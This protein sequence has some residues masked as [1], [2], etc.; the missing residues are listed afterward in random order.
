MR[1]FLLSALKR[2]SRMNAEQLRTLLTSFEEEY[3]LF[4]ATMD[5]IYDGLILLDKANI[6]VKVNRAASRILNIHR[7]ELQDKLFWECINCD[8]IALFVK[9]VII[10]EEVKKTETFILN[11]NTSSTPVYIEVSIFP[12]VLEKKVIG[13]IIVLKD[14]TKEKQDEIRQHRLESLASLSNAAAGVAHEINNPIGAMSIHAQ[15]LEKKINTLAIDNDDK[16]KILKHIHV[17][18]EEIES[19]NKTVVNFLFAVRPI[20]FEFTNIHINSL[21]NS[22]VELYDEEFKEA[23]IKIVLDL[24]PTIHTILGDERFIRQAFVNIFTNAKA[25]M[26]EGGNFFISTYEKDNLVYISFEDTGCGIDEENIQKIFQPYFTT[27]PEGTGLGLTL[28]YKVIKEHG[29]D[30]FLH[31]EKNRGTTFIFSL[32]IL[33][34]TE[35][36]LLESPIA[37]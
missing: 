19:L 35:K 4:V 23:S 30:I 12:L 15:L 25:A 22:I 33:R 21:I 10:N 26:T 17:I 32:P 6:V 9:E 8:K 31:S 24:D 36:L 1:E 7:G 13:N 28:T 3:S 14:V 20:S 5:S 11:S 37:T 2:A 18:T 34:K 16:E 29:G 27:K